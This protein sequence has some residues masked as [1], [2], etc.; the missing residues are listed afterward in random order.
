MSDISNGVPAWREEAQALPNFSPARFEV[1]AESTALL[2]VDLQYVDAHPEYGL[3]ANLKENFPDVWDYYFTRMREIVMPNCVALLHQFRAASMRVVHL[4]IGP[5]LS[6][7]VDMSPLRR[8]TTAPGLQPM[9][10]HV[11]TFEHGILPEVAPVTGELVINK[12]SRSAFNSTAIEIVLRNLGVRTLV[13][14]GVTTS[15]C[16]DTTARDAADRGFQVAIV[17]D[18]VAELD[19]PSHEAALRQFAVRWG[20][21]WTTAETG[22]RLSMGQAATPEREAAAR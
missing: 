20:R 11:G 6:D 7:G 15:S 4:T 18:A 13:V 22:E 9:L 19:E 10:H 2:L 3:G 12:T 14:A 17:E 5:Q 16:V 1:D 21:V 8:P